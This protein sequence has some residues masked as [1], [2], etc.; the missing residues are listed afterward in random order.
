M[1]RIAILIG[2]HL[3]TA[4]R[5]QKEALALQEAGHSVKI[6]G[7]WFDD[8]FIERDRMLIHDLG[9]DFSPAV[10]FDRARPVARM[11]TRAYSRLSRSLYSRC[12][13]NMPSALGYGAADL[14]HAAKTEWAD[15]T[16]VHSEVALWVGAKLR[17]MGRA[18][19]V[20]FEDW[21][22]EDLP[23]GQRRERPVGWLRDLETRLLRDCRYR[24]TTSEAL[25]NALGAAA[26]VS[27]P[28]VVYNVFPRTASP[29]AGVNRDRLDFDRTSLHWFSQTIGEGRGLEGLCHALHYIEAPVQLHLRGRSSQETRERLLKLVPPQL[30]EFVFF[31]DTVANDEL[32]FRIAEHDVGLALEP[33][34]IVSRNLT[35]TNKFFQYLTAGLAVVASNTAGQVE[36]MQRCQEAGTLFDD[37]DPSSLAR[38]L[39]SLLSDRESLASAKAAALD[40]SR[41]VFAWE[42]EAPKVVRAAERALSG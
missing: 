21:F 10:R 9:L 33:R 27:P 25:A 18:V 11:R 2:G 22:S 30:R 26:G 31:H 41:E 37:G 1:A 20:D 42:L 32:P 6:L 24:I 16:I 8:E 23:P 3:C 12:G 7:T 17:D 28:D 29:R 14:L 4:P 40:A 36:A 39:N 5:P 13:L 35:I 38:A 15:L 34:E 19:G